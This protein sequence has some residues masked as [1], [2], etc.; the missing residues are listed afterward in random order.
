M[1]Y[2]ITGLDKPDYIVSSVLALGVVRL[3]KKKVF[4]Q[5]Q[6]RK[7]GTTYFCQKNAVGIAPGN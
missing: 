2:S 6:R 4:F 3:I 1:R 7:F 5:T